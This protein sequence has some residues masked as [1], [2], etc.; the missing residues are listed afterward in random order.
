[1]IVF[2]AAGAAIAG[3]RIQKEYLRN[4]K[5]YENMAYHLSKIEDEIKES[6]DEERF[7]ILLDRANEIINLE[8]QDWRVTFSFHKVEP[9]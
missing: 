1:M 4:W 8:H 6:K 2:P 5:R 7:K 3:L 9:P